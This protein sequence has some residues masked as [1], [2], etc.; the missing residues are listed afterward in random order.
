MKLVEEKLQNDN[1]MVGQYSRTRTANENGG[2]KLQI[3]HT[4]ITEIGGRETKYRKIE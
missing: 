4:F 2:K 3:F 1:H